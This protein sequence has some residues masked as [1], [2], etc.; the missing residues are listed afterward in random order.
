MFA[1]LKHRTGTAI[2]RACAG[3]KNGEVEKGGGGGGGCTK[4]YFGDVKN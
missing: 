1:R 2:H 3:L 4:I